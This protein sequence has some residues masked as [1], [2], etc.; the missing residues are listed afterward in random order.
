M[1]T[2][3]SRQFSNEP[4]AGY[5]TVGLLDNLTFLPVFFPFILYLLVMFLLA[6][7]V[8]SVKCH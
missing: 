6:D 2:P 4:S 8:K 7:T 3:N 1:K 5:F